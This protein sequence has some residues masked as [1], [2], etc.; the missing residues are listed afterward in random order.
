MAEKRT[1][2]VGVFIKLSANEEKAFEEV[3]D[4]H[5]PN[6]PKAA[7]A[8]MALFYV[9]QRAEKDGYPVMMAEILGAL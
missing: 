7:F 2:N 6:M 1:D 9:L 3:L 5:A 8:R 4:R